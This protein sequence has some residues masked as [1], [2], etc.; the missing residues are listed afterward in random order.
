MAYDNVKASSKDV[1]DYL[2]KL[3]NKVEIGEVTDIEGSFGTTMEDG[4]YTVDLS[5][6]FNKFSIK[7]KKEDN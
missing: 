5:I 4:T 7:N 6:K 3:A 1:A 2:R